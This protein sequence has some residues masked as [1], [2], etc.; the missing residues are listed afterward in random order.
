[1]GLVTATRF[2]NAPHPADTATFAADLPSFRIRISIPPLPGAGPPFSLL[3]SP[4]TPN[5][6]RRCCS[7]AARPAALPLPRARLPAPPPGRRRRDDPVPA[8]RAHVCALAPA[9]ADRRDTLCASLAADTGTDALRRAWGD[10]A[11]EGCSVSAGRREA[12]SATEG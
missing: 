4:L 1:M 8:A 3:S 5:D 10:A 2:V 11:L 7:H 9:A 6:V 12:A